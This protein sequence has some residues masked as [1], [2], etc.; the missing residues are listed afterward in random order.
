MLGSRFYR[1]E[2]MSSAGAHSEWI[3]IKELT[4]ERATIAVAPNPADTDKHRRPYQTGISEEHKGATS[5][6]D[7]AAQGLRLSP[8]GG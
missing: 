1:R 5:T 4:N 2:S 3:T 7:R 6:Q 8:L